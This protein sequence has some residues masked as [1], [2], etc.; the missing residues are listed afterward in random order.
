MYLETKYVLYIPPYNTVCYMGVVYSCRSFEK[1]LRNINF[2]LMETF[3]FFF[4]STSYLIYLALPDI[5]E[6]IFYLL[7]IIYE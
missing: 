5:H 6:K 1:I 7:R 3:D 2:P 4:F